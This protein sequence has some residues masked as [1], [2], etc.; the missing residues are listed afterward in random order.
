VAGE[1]DDPLFEAAGIGVEAGDDERD[2]HAGCR[3][4]DG[5][6][7]IAYSTGRH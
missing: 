7:M 5:R 4:N 1:A 3:I 6:E 2:L